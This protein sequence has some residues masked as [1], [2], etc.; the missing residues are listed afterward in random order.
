MAPKPET[1][2]VLGSTLDHV[3][4]ARRSVF[5]LSDQ[6]WNPPTDVFESDG[7]IVIKMEIAGV[8]PEDLEVT[9]VDR[10]LVIRGR[11]REPR[12]ASIA[13]YHVLE[14]GYGEF[15]R[16]FEFPF[17]LTMEDVK[18]SYQQGFLCVEAPKTA[19]RRR[20]VPL[21]NAGSSG[22]QS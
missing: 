2:R 17:R 19:P 20:R 22:G 5:T 18:A 4:G 12:G 9:T 8:D 13:T 1:S 15:E 10:L 16:V 11:R 7:V 6:V 3:C 14:V 21:S